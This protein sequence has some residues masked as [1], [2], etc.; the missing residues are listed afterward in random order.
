MI[1]Y[2]LYNDIYYLILYFN[3]YINILIFI[4]IGLMLKI[5]YYLKLGS[6]RSGNNY[7]FLSIYIMIF[8]SY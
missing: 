6:F 4:L 5:I 2:F 3:Y 1:V 8:I 7:Y